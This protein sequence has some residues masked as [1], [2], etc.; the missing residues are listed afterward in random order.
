MGQVPA[1]LRAKWIM[2]AAASIAEERAR[3][4][5]GPAAIGDLDLLAAIAREGEGDAYLALAAL[6]EVAETTRLLHEAA[7]A[8]E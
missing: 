5:G 1:T 6:C 8:S 4:E 3:R 2:T 7:S